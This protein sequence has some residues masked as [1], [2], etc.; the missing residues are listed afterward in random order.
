MKLISGMRLTIRH[1]ML[2][3]F[4]LVVF[5]GLLSLL[6]VSVTITE[7]NVSRLINQDVVQ[8]KKSIDLYIGQY[9]LSKN[10]TLDQQSF[11]TEADSLVKELSASVSA[12]ISVYD[13]EGKGLSRLNSEE[14][15]ASDDFAESMGGKIAYSVIRSGSSSVVSL[16]SPVESNGKLIGI[17]HLKKNYSELDAF[18]NRFLTA[19]R[20]FAVAIFVLVFLTAWLLA[21]RITKPVARLAKSVKRVAE[22]IYEPVPVR[23]GNDEIME[24]T[25]GYNLMMEQIQEQ[26]AMIERER[27]ALQITQQMSKTFFDNVTH[28]LKTPL[29]TI[30]GYAQIME[31]NGFQD[32]P[33][34]DKG[35]RYIIDESK[36]LNEKVVQLLLFSTAGSEQIAY[37][38]ERVGLSALAGSVC[39][40]MA[41]RGDKYGIQ[42][43]F[44]ADEEPLYIR[45]DREKLREMLLNVLDNAV[46]YGGVHSKITVALSR[47][48]ADRCL[49]RVADQGAGIPEENLS[50]LFEPYYRLA[51]ANSDE[52]RG[53][54]GLGL[55]IVQTIAQRHGGQVVI[56]SAPGKGTCVTMEL[57]GVLNV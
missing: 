44:L 22:G 32:K 35:M 52:E 6:L 39:E 48:G 21:N 45:G 19:I 11:Q 9:Y 4:T 20:W 18:T 12:P 3:S 33:F 57:G 43:H 10:V 16:S 40:D 24:L 1:K 53:S 31:E 25:Q 41:V 8:L 14:L 15:P 27:D 50:H 29:T 36:R 42:I 56:E 23:G 34:F 46:K 51:S 13:A 37:R 7:Q 55:A 26:I 30:R 54:A 2:L 5:A 47:N 28:E 17:V 49:I 38:F